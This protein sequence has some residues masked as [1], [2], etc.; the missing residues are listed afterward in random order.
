M[1]KRKHNFKTW[2]SLGMERVMFFRPSEFDYPNQ[3]NRVVLNLLDYMRGK[4][5][6]HQNI[7]ITINSDFRPGDPK[8]HGMGLAVDIVIRDAETKQPLPVLEQFFMALCY[9]WRGVGMYPFWKEPG[10]HVDM[11]NYE[12]HNNRKALWWKDAEG[13]YRIMKDFVANHCFWR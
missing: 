8:A 6:E 9:N 2:H 3:M 12:E 13:K 10:I 11:R 5:G 4:E 1:K 7:I